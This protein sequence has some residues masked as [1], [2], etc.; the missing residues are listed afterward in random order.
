MGDD[1]RLKCREIDHK[2][3]RKLCLDLS[4]PGA[5]P[6]TE[7]DDVLSRYHADRQHRR[8]LVV[9]QSRGAIGLC[10]AGAHG[11]N[12]TELDSLSGRRNQQRRSPDRS[13][14]HT[15]ELQSLMRISYAVFC[16]KKK[17]N[18]KLHKQDIQRTSSIAVY[19]L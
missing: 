14:E 16:L 3:D 9:H 12:V 8:G 7:I 5:Q 1:V 19:G 6:V 18:K 13:E 17:N 10:I 15:S 4:H 11:E 2:A